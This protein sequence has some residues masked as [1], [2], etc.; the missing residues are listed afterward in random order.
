M[1]GSEAYMDWMSLSSGMF[2]T[3]L[4]SRA[5]P[6]VPIDHAAWASGETQLVVSPAGPV[7]P[8]WRERR[9]YKRRGEGG[10]S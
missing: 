7:N 1:T 4:L 9:V 5:A 2:S 3:R 8:S 6:V 10:E